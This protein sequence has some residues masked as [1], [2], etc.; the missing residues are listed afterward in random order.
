MFTPTF[1]GLETRANPSSVTFANHVITITGDAAVNDCAVTVTQDRRILV[2]LDSIH[3]EW[4]LDNVTAINTNLSG[5]GDWFVYQNGYSDETTDYPPVDDSNLTLA[6]NLGGGHDAVV[7]LGC[8]G[9][10]FV[11]N[12]NGGD[13]ILEVGGDSGGCTLRGGAG[14]DLLV[15]TW[16]DDLIQGGAGDDQIDGEDGNDTL[17]GGTGADIIFASDYLGPVDS[18]LVYYDAAD[19][20]VTHDADDTLILV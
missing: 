2:D 6:V 17:D 14:D 5:N 8:A 4:K 15:G 3:K 1:E 13:D 12:G 9:A 16:G 18:D 19:V 11:L 10:R 7:I 20:L